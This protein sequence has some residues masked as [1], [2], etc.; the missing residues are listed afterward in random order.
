MSLA[1][2]YEKFLVPIIMDHWAKKIARIIEPGDHV[3]DVGCGTGAVTR[4]AAEITGECGKVVGLDMN[5]DMLHVARLVAMPSGR[6]VDWVEADA[7]LMPFEDA[8]FD[9]VLCQFSLMFMTDKAAALREMRRVLKPGGS[10]GLSVFVSGPYDKALR[11]ALGKHVAPDEI[12]FAI[13]SCGNPDWLCSIVAEAGFEIISLKEESASSC[14]TSVRQS[15]ELMK[16]WS[17]AIAGLPDDVFD[18]FSSE[19]EVEMREFN[20]ADGFACPEPVNIV[21]SRAK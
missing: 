9:V 7:A 11:K 18:Q 15:V 6:I 19:V 8:E 21:T 16:D 14:Y 17:E 2:K 20:T 13:W 3:L 5:P 1:E 12:N 10:F 4:H